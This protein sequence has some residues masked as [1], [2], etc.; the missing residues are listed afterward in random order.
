MAPWHAGHSTCLWL[1]V[2]LLYKGY[3][4]YQIIRFLHLSGDFMVRVLLI[5][6]WH[7]GFM[8]SISVDHLSLF[9]SIENQIDIFICL[10]K[11]IIYLQIYLLNCLLD[12]EREKK[13]SGIFIINQLNFHI[14]PQETTAK[15]IWKYWQKWKEGRGFW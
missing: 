15:I 6:W 12:K 9:W 1:W 11:W 3:Y 8:V 14:K 4:H 2:V 13:P 7:T 5:S 10:Y